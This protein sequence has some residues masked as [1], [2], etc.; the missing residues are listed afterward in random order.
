V[1]L[2]GSDLADRVKCGT[3]IPLGGAFHQRAAAVLTSLSS[4]LACAAGVQNPAVACKP[5]IVE[6]NIQSEMWSDTHA[7]LSM[8][9]KT[10]V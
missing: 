9:F 4:L 6:T 2:K 10:G 1:Q 7:L 3:H 5:H 8:V